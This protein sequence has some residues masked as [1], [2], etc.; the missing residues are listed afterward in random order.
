M[1]YYNPQNNRS[2]LW[3]SAALVLYLALWLWLIL[4]VSFKMKSPPAED[5]M[6]VDFGQEQTGAG[7]EDLLLAETQTPQPARQI[8]AVDNPELLTS[9]VEESVVVQER[10]PQPAHAQERVESETVKTEEQP[11]ERQV[12]RQALFPGRNQTQTSQAQSQGATD[13]PTGNQGGES[14]QQGDT[15]ESSREGVTGNNIAID[16]E[17]RR[18][19]GQIPKPQYLS[20]DQGKVVINIVVDANGSVSRATYRAVGSTTSDSR[21][22]EAALEAA[23]KARFTPSQ[24]QQI[25]SG[26][27]TYVFKKI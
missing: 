9:D 17:G 8:E 15:Y 25:Q 26:T 3:A 12:N 14:S 1:E 27:I 4:T 21:L 2:K 7:E 10:K 18:P 20:D 5:G 24:S 6:I 19:V 11:E 13:Q 23:H 16:L 22:I